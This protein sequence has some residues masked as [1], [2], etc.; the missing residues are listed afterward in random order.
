MAANGESTPL[1]HEI[2]KAHQEIERW[3]SQQRIVTAATVCGFIISIIPAFFTL[4]VSVMAN[5][6]AKDHE[7]KAFT[8]YEVLNMTGYHFFRPAVFL[9]G[10]LATQFVLQNS[11]VSRQTKMAWVVAMLALTSTGIIVGIYMAREVMQCGVVF[12]WGAETHEHGTGDGMG[13]RA[14]EGLLTAIFSLT[15]LVPCVVMLLK[16]VRDAVQPKQSELK[17]IEEKSRIFQRRRAWA[18]VLLSGLIIP[19][20]FVITM[21]MPNNFQKLHLHGGEAN[22]RLPNTMKEWV[23]DAEK[24]EAWMKTVNWRISE[25]L[26][27]KLYPDTMIFYGFLE[28]LGLTALF[29][30]YFPSV[31]KLLSR[32]HPGGFSIGEIFSM[33]LLGVTFFL[34]TYYWA[35]QHWW[36]HIGWKFNNAD[37]VT[38]P[39]ASGWEVVARTCGMEAIFFMS[40]C[41]LPA[42]RSSL[43]LE[44]MGISWESS[45]WTHRWLGALMLI[46]MAGHAVGYWIRWA[47][48]GIFPRDLFYPPF[49]PLRPNTSLDHKNPD[50]ADMTV[51]MMQ[52]IG[53][54]SLVTM[55]LFPLFR[56]RCYELFKYFHY[57]F[58]VLVPAAV[59]H[60]HNGW[61]FPVGSIAFWL[62]DAAMRFANSSMSQQLVLA[63]AHA[64]ETGMTELVF[65]MHFPEPGMYCFV[66]VPQISR[67]EW[68]PFSFSSSPLDDK[69]SL[70]IKTVSP[71]QF[72]GKLHKL[73]N[74]CKEQNP[75][76]TLN[77]EGP[78]GPALDLGDH[79]G[80]LLL[81]GGVG[82]TPLHSTMRYLMQ[83]ACAKKLPQTLKMVRLVLVARTAGIVNLFENSLREILDA[84]LASPQFSMQLFL[85]CA[86][87]EAPALNVPFQKGRPCFDEVYEKALKDLG[88]GSL[89]VKL[90]APEAMDKQASK[91]AR[92]KPRIHYESELFVM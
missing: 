79:S 18:G 63:K 30:T 92:G 8:T 67:L 50:G 27:L 37:G 3:W 71:D 38:S 46:A 81:A 66:N 90:C 2:E 65:E 21:I 24:P 20:I 53:Y 88:D 80:M 35:S 22:Y 77:V 48:M 28:I 23:W 75:P 29:S 58:L 5:F 34:W 6:F 73:V 32:R 62:V 86:E 42:S 25:D 49:Y 47:E 9:L 57:T 11:R 87:V 16:L 64:M 33:S 17:P 43:W 91:A 74:Q 26:V 72:T 14:N 56:R 59:L 7:Y 61:Y 89:L 10:V 39:V 76:I 52:L 78:Y 51:Y 15:L 55:G 44:A 36:G 70:H 41:L 45:L 19:M 82:L 84:E 40:L 1:S 13:L 60:A 69:A 68:H 4:R 85:T 54:P 31:K 12:C 83:L